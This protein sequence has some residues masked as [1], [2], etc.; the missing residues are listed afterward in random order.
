MSQV[1]IS[2][3]DLIAALTAY[4]WDVVGARAGEYT[5]LAI[6][7]GSRPRHMLVVPLDESAPEFELMMSQLLAHLAQLMV[8]GQAARQV[9]RQ[10]GLESGS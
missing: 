8:D 4:G 3:A 2:P 7:D 5:R 1:E 10:V 9:L 6:T